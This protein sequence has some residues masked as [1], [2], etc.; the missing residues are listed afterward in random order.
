MLFNSCSSSDDSNPAKPEL[1]V[2]GIKLYTNFADSWGGTFVDKAENLGAILN[3]KKV[4][5]VKEILSDSTVMDIKGKATFSLDDNSILDVVPLEKGLC[6]VIGK[7]VKQG[8]VTIKYNGHE[9]TLK[10]F[11]NYNVE[12][13]WNTYQSKDSVNWEFLQI[14]K[15]YQ[16]PNKNAFG[17]TVETP[18]FYFDSPTSKTFS[19]QTE[20][21]KG[22]ILDEKTMEYYSPGTGTYYRYEKR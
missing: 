6:E 14:D 11:T 18:D 1:K 5:K 9:L 4:Y 12:G 17:W 8:K 3:G 16:Q 10:A 20:N 7:S 15:F 19:T 22:K 2:V 13:E 21:G